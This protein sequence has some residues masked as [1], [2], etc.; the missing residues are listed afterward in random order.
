MISIDEVK[1]A[2]K[3]ARL[4]LTEEEAAKFSEQLGVILEY[5]SQI[6]EVNTEGIEPM[7]H[8]VPVYNVFRE[9]AV[10]YEETKEELMKNAPY[11][12]NG[13]FRVPKIN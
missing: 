7:P 11:E 12:E 2:A 6:S 9:D 13:F 8:A 10:K 4:E 3:L 5:A 1:H